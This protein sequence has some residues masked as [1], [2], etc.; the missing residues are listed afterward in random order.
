MEFT[1]TTGMGGA[2]VSEFSSII[3]DADHCAGLIY[4][5][6]W[7]DD[8]ALTLQNYSMLSTLRH[9]DTLRA[10]HRQRRGDIRRR[11]TVEDRYRIADGDG[12][13]NSH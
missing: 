4:R 13:A 10:E 2:N 8:I 5:R 9:N 12:Y 7:G 1:V 11:Q 6:A 3:V